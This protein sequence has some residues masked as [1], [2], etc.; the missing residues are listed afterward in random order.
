[1]AAIAVVMLI[2]ASALLL[3]GQVSAPSDNGNEVFTSA[4]SSVSEATR[5]FFGIR[6][7]PEQ[8]IQFV[9][10]V[11]IEDVQLGCVDCHITVERGPRAS[12]PDIRTCWGCHED[13]FVDHPEVAKIKVFHDKGE[14][15]PWQRVYGWNDESHVHFNHAPH[16]RSDVGCETC[17]GK[18][19]QMT[20]ASRAVEHS[21][22]FCVKC[23]QEKQASTDCLTCHY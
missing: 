8:P 6:P 14:D 21:M 4:H 16:V 22:G 20:V 11:H 3:T 5:H 2:G 15:I 9:H 17:H 23:H 10:K 13:A 12:I 7:E 18:V 1:M 19:E